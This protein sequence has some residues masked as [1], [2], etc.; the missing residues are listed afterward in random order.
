MLYY[1]IENLRKFFW[2]KIF[3]LKLSIEYVVT[4]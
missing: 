1:I 3:Y 4:F 2:R